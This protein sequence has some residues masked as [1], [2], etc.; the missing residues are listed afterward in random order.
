M[1]TGI[2][3]TPDSPN[4]EPHSDVIATPEGDNEMAPDQPLQPSSDAAVSGLET[5]RGSKPDEY[6]K[7][8][9]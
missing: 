7:D 9:P 8:K 1:T 2:R 6:K 5:P 3:P 4:D